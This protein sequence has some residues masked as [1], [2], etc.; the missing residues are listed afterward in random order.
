MGEKKVFCVIPAYNEEKN[1]KK[2][3]EGLVDIVDYLV[4][5]VDGGTDRTFEKALETKKELEKR[6]ENLYIL[7]HVVNR[8]QGA[9]LQTGN[10]FSLKMGADLV[11]HFDADGQFLNEDIKSV[12]EPILKDEADVVFGSRFLGKESN[13]PWFK[14]NIIFKLAHLFNFFF[15]KIKLTD[16]QSGFR[17]MN[18]K[19]LTIISIDQDKMAHCSEILF[20]VS[21]SDLRVKEVPVLVLYNEYGQKFSGGIKIV[22]DLVFSK[23]FK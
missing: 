19:A 5:V 22:R 3:I 7:K 20:K 10:E 17:A 6:A 12:I 8:G 14:K 16:P 15:V 13:I 11:V 23:I 4:L 18:K 21:E 1:I 9:A 2:V